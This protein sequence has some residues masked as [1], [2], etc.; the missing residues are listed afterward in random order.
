MD[1]SRA[2][3]IGFEP[4][5]NIEEGIKEVMK[6]YQENKEIVNK[7]YNVFTKEKV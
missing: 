1:I 6:W 7:R 2:K 3:A 4:E 5:I